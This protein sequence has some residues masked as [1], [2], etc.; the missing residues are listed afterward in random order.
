MLAGETAAHTFLTGLATTAL[1]NNT[2]FV[3]FATNGTFL[4]S[5]KLVA[6]LITANPTKTAPIAVSEVRSLTGGFIAAL[7]VGGVMAEV[8]LILI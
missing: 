3:L 8:D 6:Y 7:A 5:S 1:I 4:G 2:K